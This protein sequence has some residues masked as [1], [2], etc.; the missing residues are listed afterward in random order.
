[1]KRILFTALILIVVK[2]AVAQPINLEV[3]AGNDYL[4]YQHLIAK[5]FAAQSPFGFMHIANV[6]NRYQTDIKKGGRPN[7][8]MNQVYITSAL[9]KHF[10]LLTGIFYNHVTGIRASAG[11]Q[12][13]MPF[14]NGLFVTVPRADIE[15]RGS[16]EMMSMLE[17]QP[18]ITKTVKLY[19]RLQVMSNYGAFRHNRSYQRLR[20]GINLKG[21]QFGAAM[22]LDEYGKESKLYFNTGIFIRKE[23]I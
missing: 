8:V 4:F 14:K 3:M 23:I 13:A 2:L 17:Y 9:N 21:V 12:F 7:E 18:A 1:M 6:S 11:I 16:V 22:N 19:S 15:H 10:T 5:K 20:L